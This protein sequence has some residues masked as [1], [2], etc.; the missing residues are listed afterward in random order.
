MFK[1]WKYITVRLSGNEQKNIEYESFTQWKII[2]FKL[3]VQI[4]QFFFV[5][6]HEMQC[7]LYNK[8]TEILLLSFNPYVR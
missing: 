7:K 8:S 4:N 5:L 6:K 1:Y 2:D 3:K